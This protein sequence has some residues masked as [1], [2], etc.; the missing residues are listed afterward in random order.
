MNFAGSSLPWATDR[1][2]PMPSARHASSSSTSICRPAEWASSVAS[3]GDVRRASS[4]WPVRWPV[5]RAQLT[6]SPTAVPRRMCG[7]VINL[8]VADDDQH[9]IDRRQRMVL[10]AGAVR[11]RS[12]ECEVDALDRRLNRLR[13]GQ[14]LRLEHDADFL[15]RR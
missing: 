3:A 15:G 4:G 2:L 9:F 11:V 12:P 7:V 1:K 13:G 6:A 14:R 10:F 8:A 5:E